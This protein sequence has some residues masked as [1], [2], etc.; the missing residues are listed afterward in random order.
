MRVTDNM[1]FSSAMVA[2]RQSASRLHDASGV[3]SSGIAVS[4][5]SD[6]P[7]V[8]AAI[9][10]KD[11]AI[12]R[13]GARQQAMGRSLGDLH[14]AEGALVEAADLMIRAREIATQM[15]DGA[16]GAP[17]R[18]IAAQEVAALRQELIA[19]ANTQ[20]ARGHLFAGTATDTPAFSSGGLFQGNDN[21][22]IVEIA[23]GIV[24]TANISGQ[25][26]FTALSGGQDVFQDLATLEAALSGNNQAGIHQSIAT[27]DSGQEQLVA[28]RAQV[29][30]RLNRL[31]S[32]S[33]VTEAALLATRD[34][35]AAEAEAE[36][37]EAFT[38]LSLAETAYQQSLAIA[39]NI[40]QMLSSI[41]RF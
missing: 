4:R 37:H 18:A 39:R 6:A 29:G 7:A 41:E 26:A 12:A 15:A 31:Q 33:Q 1:R 27:L 9:V 34:A 11:G 20:G 21:A 19:L 36:P 14:I 22:M 24:V 13:L 25:R 10:R 30:I 32:A 2:M 5:P 8:Y 16:Y 38:E 28:S 35:R 23:E 3:A 17:E 40:L